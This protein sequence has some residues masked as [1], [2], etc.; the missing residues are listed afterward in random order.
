MNL[1]HNKEYKYFSKEFDDFPSVYDNY[2]PKAFKYFFQ[3]MEYDL[4]ISTLII[5]EV[6]I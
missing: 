4:L 2:N 1:Y 3:N 5:D 6:F